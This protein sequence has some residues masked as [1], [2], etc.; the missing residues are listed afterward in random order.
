MTDKRTVRQNS[1]L[2]GTLSAY[3][4]DLNNAGYDY[5]VFIEMASKRGFK[6]AWSKNNLHELFNT[7]S[8]AMN[9]GRTSSELT[10][11]EMSDTYQV[12]ERHLAEC[13]GVSH[14]WHSKEQQML[15]ASDRWW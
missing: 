11:K 8:K 1:S 3:A 7:V 10:T 4:D 12:F 6:V 2:F 13:S 15:E 5:S 14:A 9:D